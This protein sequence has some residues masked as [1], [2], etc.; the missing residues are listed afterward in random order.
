MLRGRRRGAL[1]QEA[2][3]MHTHSHAHSRSLTISVA[4]A[5]T[6]THP[7]PLTPTH[8]HSHAHSRS[9]TLTYS[10]KLSLALLLSY[11][12][13]PSLSLTHTLSLSHAPC[14]WRPRRGQHFIRLAVPLPPPSLQ[15]LLHRNL[16]VTRQLESNRRPASAGVEP[17]I[18]SAGVK[19]ERHMLTRATRLPLDFP[20]A[21][22]R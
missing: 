6:H 17:G 20:S 11:P 8:A 9:L 7:R 18:A 2:R 10:R 22:P 19:Q 16:D 5:H 3:G 21:S 4:L 14:D 15:L 1:G 12:L 13:S